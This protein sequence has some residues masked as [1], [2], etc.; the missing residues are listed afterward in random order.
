MQEISQILCTLRCTFPFVCFFAKNLGE[1]SI[2]PRQNPDRTARI[3][4][5][6]IGPLSSHYR[7]NID[8]LSKE[9]SWQ[10]KC[11]LSH[12]K[13]D[14]RHQKCDYRQQ[15]CDYS[16]LPHTPYNIN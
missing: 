16:Q 12:Q 3:S 5:R 4:F 7:A 9:C 2:K 1:S 13:C 14:Y 6:S 8:P 11:R 15:K 10:R